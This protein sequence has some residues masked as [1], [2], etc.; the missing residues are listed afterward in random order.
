VAHYRGLEKTKIL[1]F[2]KSFSSREKA[3]TV[4][5]L[6]SLGLSHF[7]NLWLLVSSVLFII[8]PDPENNFG[9]TY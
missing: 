3:A 4:T 7:S 2:T 5:A 9:T 6:R 1:L 8:L